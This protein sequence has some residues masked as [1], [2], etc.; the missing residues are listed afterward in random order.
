MNSYSLESQSHLR[1]VAHRGR[2]RCWWRSLRACW[3]QL[4]GPR[5]RGGMARGREAPQARRPGCPCATTP[6]LSLRATSDASR[7]SRHHTVRSFGGTTPSDQTTPSRSPGR[8]QTEGPAEPGRRSVL[9]GPRRGASFVRWPGIWRTTPLDLRVEV[10]KTPQ[11]ES[12]RP[13]G[14]ASAASCPA[15]GAENARAVGLSPVW[16]CRC[17]RPGPA[18]RGET[19]KRGG[20]VEGDSHIA[21]GCWPAALC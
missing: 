6:R 3:W 5:W 20:V 8:D 17:R 12:T 9:L 21:G 19:I 1:R 10:D 11:F 18:R 7:H 15:R 4:W 13:P 14:S 16:R 2:S